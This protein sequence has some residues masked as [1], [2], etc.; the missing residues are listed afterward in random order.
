MGRYLAC[1]LLCTSH[2]SIIPI[3]SDK[4]NIYAVASLMADMGW[5][6]FTGQMPPVLSICLGENHAELSAKRRDANPDYKPKGAAAI[7]G[8]MNTTPAAI[9]EQVVRNYVDVKLSVKRQVS[10][11]E[12]LPTVLRAYY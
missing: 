4:Y 1:T 6:L 11:N 8:A 10:G 3:A 9:L 12:P 5:N 2:A 7:Y